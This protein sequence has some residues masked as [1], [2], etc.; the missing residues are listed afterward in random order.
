MKS[1]SRTIWLLSFAVLAACVTDPAHTGSQEEW[2]LVE[3]E[4][5]GTPEH[6]SRAI[7]PEHF[8]DHPTSERIYEVYSRPYLRCVDEV[9]GREKDAPT[10]GSV[11]FWTYFSPP[12]EGEEGHQNFRPDFDPQRYNLWLRFPNLSSDWHRFIIDYQI[13]Y[14]SYSQHNY[15]RD[16]LDARQHVR[17][18]ALPEKSVNLWMFEMADHC[19]LVTDEEVQAFRDRYS[20]AEVMYENPVTGL[21]VHFETA[22]ANK[23]MHIDHRGVPTTGKGGVVLRYEHLINGFESYSSMCVVCDVPDEDDDSPRWVENPDW[24]TRTGPDNPED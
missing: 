23:I 20:R 22:R 18:V 10:I 4:A 14:N 9:N 11:R 13:D 7:L 12:I 2:P 19:G 5:P 6:P 3:P 21:V 8:I 15:W 16:S 1:T 17:L 24:V